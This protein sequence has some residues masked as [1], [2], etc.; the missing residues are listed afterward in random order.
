MPEPGKVFAYNRYMYAYGNA[1]K[2]TDPSGHIAVCYRGGFREQ[3][4]ASG[5]DGSSDMWDVCTQA[6]L[7]AG[8]DEA[9]HGE[10]LK[11]KNNVEAQKFAANAIL[12]QE[13]SNP[14]LPVIIVGHSW[15]GAAA[16][17]TANMVADGTSVSITDGSGSATVDLLFVI[18]A[19]SFARRGG[20]RGL[21]S[22]NVETFVNAYAKELEGQGAQNGIDFF[23]GAFNFPVH[24][25][26][27]FGDGVVRE[28]NHHT[29]SH[30]IAG[31]PP[32]LYPNPVTYG[33]L[34]D[35]ASQALPWQDPNVR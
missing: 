32:T 6:L 5:S 25:N 27:D 12:A 4:V 19:V 33:L 8:Y 26:V 24:T 31:D 21:E 34:A 29:V 17:R 23:E 22:D 1:L 28:V 13:Q 14:H 20:S 2:Y 35:Y 30:A 7:N 18:D 10:I 11:L 16:I 9:I 3:G 15:G